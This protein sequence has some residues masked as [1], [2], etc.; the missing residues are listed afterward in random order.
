MVTVTVT[1]TVTCVCVHLCSYRSLFNLNLVI[2]RPIAPAPPF[3][4]LWQVLLRLLLLLLFFITGTRNDIRCQTLCNR[5]SK[6][7]VGKR[8]LRVLGSGFR[9]QGL[10]FR[11]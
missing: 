5:R 6:E 8:L 11:V 3:F 10:G 9:V 1:V 7:E 2:P 4:R